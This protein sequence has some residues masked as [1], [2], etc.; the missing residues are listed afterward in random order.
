MKMD[1]GWVGLI[2]CMMW[3]AAMG[4]SSKWFPYLGGEGLFYF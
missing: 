2:L 1:E 3:E 4:S